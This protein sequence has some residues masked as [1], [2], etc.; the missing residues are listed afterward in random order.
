MYG[1]SYFVI[2]KNM[3]AEKCSYRAL[4]EDA[5]LVSL[6][7]KLGSLSNDDGYAEDNA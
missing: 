6:G 7:G 5:M 3:F 1:F 4:Y 2:W